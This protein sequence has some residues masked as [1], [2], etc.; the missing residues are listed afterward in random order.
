MNLGGAGNAFG[1]HP[2]GTPRKKIEAAV[3]DGQHAY[4]TLIATKAPDELVGGYS[5]KMYP[6][7]VVVDAE[8]KVAA[9]GSLSEVAEAFGDL[10][11]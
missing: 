7:C 8:G 11:P 1:V 5:V 9:H 6:Y 3:K 10:H 2:A 4:P